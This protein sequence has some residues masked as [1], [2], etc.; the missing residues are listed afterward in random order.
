MDRTAGLGGCA[1]PACGINQPI[2]MSQSISIVGNGTVCFMGCSSGGHVVQVV[3]KGWGCKHHGSV[4]NP[5]F[6]T[7]AGMG[8]FDLKGGFS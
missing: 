2:R 7:A 8:H 3:D 5:S 6:N 1:D 4:Q